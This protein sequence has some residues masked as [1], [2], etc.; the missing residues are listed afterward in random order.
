MAVEA[1]MR[2]RGRVA[3]HLHAARSGAED[4]AP[5]AAVTHAPTLVD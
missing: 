4:E 2:R 3:P 5:P 1:D